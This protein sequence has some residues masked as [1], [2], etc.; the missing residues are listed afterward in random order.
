MPPREVRVLCAHIVQSSSKSDW[1]YTDS[2]VK[3]QNYSK[4]KF[5]KTRFP[6]S[7][8]QHK[9]HREDVV[10]PR[11]PKLYSPQTNCRF[12]YLT[13]AEHLHRSSHE[14]TA[15]AAS[16]LAASFAGRFFTRRS[17]GRLRQGPPAVNTI[18]L[19]H[20]FEP[21]VLWS[22]DRRRRC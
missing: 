21:D 7:A 8:V 5:L 15:I 17:S 19:T 12:L 4:D 3:V 10:Q 20:R 22:A 14:H 9:A 1:Q 6:P 13:S 18:D 2:L 11:S 16:F